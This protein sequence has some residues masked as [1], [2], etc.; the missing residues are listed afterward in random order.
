[1][2]ELRVKK[3]MDRLSRENSL[4]IRASD[5]QVADKL[6]S[7]SFSAGYLCPS[8]C[9]AFD[10]NEEYIPNHFVGASG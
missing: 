7:D 5:R 8:G 10:Y 4:P 6:N 2:K 1:M 3:V 9:P